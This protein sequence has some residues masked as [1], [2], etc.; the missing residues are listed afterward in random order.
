MKKFL[1]VCGVV[2]VLMASGCK[3]SLTRET[4]L[5]GEAGGPW[6]YIYGT[7]E[8]V[9]N[10]VNFNL[11]MRMH[12]VPLVARD[13]KPLDIGATSS[14]RSYYFYRMKVGKYVIEDWNVADDT[15]GRAHP[16]G[17]SFDVKENTIT[18]LG[19][20]TFIQNGYTKDG[21]DWIVYDISSQDAMK[22][23]LALLYKD[24]PETKDL[25]VINQAWKYTSEKK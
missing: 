10:N 18:Y 2:L 13:E 23:D 22:D 5:K 16:I 25:K 21:V 4:F 1:S 6:G 14:A 8:L 3:E 24:I 15:G 20:V 11:M 19:Y 12:I 9:R 17:H 7:R